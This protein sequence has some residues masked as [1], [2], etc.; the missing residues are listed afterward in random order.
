MQA[1]ID[2]QTV[3]GS[4]RH[5]DPVAGQL[6]DLQKQH[7]ALKKT[8]PDKAKALAHQHNKLKY[9][10]IA[11]ARDQAIQALNKAKEFTMLRHMFP[12]I[13]LNI[14]AHISGQCFSSFNATLSL[15]LLISIMCNDSALWAGLSHGFLDAIWQRFLEKETMFKDMLYTR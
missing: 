4:F 10:K 7:A 2:H 3:D 8:D 6:L 12:L 15:N 5:Y 13:Y 11:T 14:F 9:T 1:F